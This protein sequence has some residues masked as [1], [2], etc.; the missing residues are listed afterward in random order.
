M[1]ICYETY[2]VMWK[3]TT[4]KIKPFLCLTIIKLWN[5]S[6]LSSWPSARLVGWNMNGYKF[7]YAIN[8]LL[9]A[10]L[11]LNK[12]LKIL[13][14]SLG[15]NSC[16]QRVFENSYLQCH[17]EFFQFLH[18]L[19]DT[20]FWMTTIFMLHL[21]WYFWDHNG[22][23]TIKINIHW[24]STHHYLAFFAASSLVVYSVIQS[25]RESSANSIVFCILASNGC[26]SL[27]VY[28]YL[29]VSIGIGYNNSEVV[30][31]DI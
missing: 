7:L 10:Q 17:G 1:A 19:C 13:Q 14:N 22:E 30:K 21:I 2:F 28:R 6:Q 23:I 11:F 24:Q 12:H 15:W 16:S 25:L 20:A 4:L 27:S 18:C 31:N 26:S 29:D 8:N 3:L 5:F 9:L